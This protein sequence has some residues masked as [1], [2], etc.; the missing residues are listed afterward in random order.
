MRVANTQH[1]LINNPSIIGRDLA[2]CDVAIND[3]SI[4]RQQARVHFVAGRVEIENLSATNPTRVRGGVV[5][6]RVELRAG[7]VIE[8][9]NLRAELHLPAGASAKCIHCNAPL[10]RPGARYCTRCGKPQTAV[11]TVHP[12]AGTQV[13]SSTRKL[14]VQLAGQGT[15]AEYP[16]SKPTHLL[17]RAPNNDILINHPFVSANHARLEQTGASYRIVD[18]GSTN[19]LLLNGKRVADHLLNHDDVIRIGDAFGNS[20]MLT[21]VDAA[22]PPVA[23]RM[24]LHLAPTTTLIGRDPN[25]TMPLNTPTIS[26]HHAQIDFD[27]ATH[28]LTDLNSTNGTFVNGARIQRHTL[29]ANDVVQIGP[30]QLVYDRSGL[31]Q[32]SILGNVRLDAL[33]LT[34][35]VPAKQGTRL[36]LNDVSLSIQPRDF[37][38]LV[39]A[40]GAGKSTLMSAL[41]GFARAEGTVLLNGADFYRDYAAYRAMLGFVP[42]QDIIHRGLPVFSALNYAAQLRLPPDWSDAQIKQRIEEVMGTVEIALQRNQLVSKLSGGQLKRVSIAAELL[43][44]PA[45]FFLDEPT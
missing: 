15:P 17:G 31:T 4:S 1:N 20:V 7:D 22:A 29:S 5:S 13:I 37:V 23:A 42:Q 3:P 12:H 40:S 19:G 44:Q 21:Y 34:R 41:N 28:T 30:F 38:A 26:W 16:L 18:A 9:G 33:H 27:G 24:R 32:F 25:A 14:I 39:G 11:P 35:R 8:M 6:G 45:L 43:A 36:I 10:S 2:A